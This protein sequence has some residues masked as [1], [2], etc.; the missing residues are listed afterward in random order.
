MY[1]SRCSGFLKGVVS[2]LCLI[3]SV[4]VFAESIRTPDLRL[5]IDISETAL[6]AEQDLRLGQSLAALVRL[7]PEG[8]QVG[9]WTF[10]E[11]VEQLAPVKAV[12]NSWKEAAALALVRVK[13]RGSGSDIPAALA[14]ASAILP[15][16]NANYDTS[17]ILLTSGRLA[18]S[19]SPM[20]NANAAREL[21]QKRAPA[22]A[23]QGIPVHT[24]AVSKDADRIFLANL[25]RLT[26]GLAVRA[27]SSGELASSLLRL[28]QTISPV[29]TL[30]IDKSRFYVDESVE[31]FT[32][33]LTGGATLSHI[34]LYSPDGDRVTREQSPP[35][36]R[37]FGNDLFTLITVSKPQVGQWKF[38]AADDAE[39]QVRVQ[40][41]LQLQIA[42]SLSVI[43]VGVTTELTLQLVLAG[44]TLDSVALYS[45]FEVSLAV[46]NPTGVI[47]ALPADLV[48]VKVSEAGYVLSLPALK[49]AGSHVFKIGLRGEGVQRELPVYVTA[50]AANPRE[51]ISTRVED[52]PEVDLK[53]P[54]I[55]FA[56]LTVIAL[57]VLLMVLRR[58]RQRKLA[59]WQQRFSDPEGKGR[60]GLFPG[61]RAEV[62]RDNKRS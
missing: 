34:A 29:S 61:I 59:L 53:I 9:I 15:A 49:Q 6:G 23:S 17:I 42:P 14:A 18:V 37:W 3:L 55:R 28:L 45:Q 30:P 8:S 43:P 57:A 44:K 31:V 4:P 50:V 47:E 41:P 7:L 52:V 38:K 58:R 40:S 46:V 12:D 39:A 19:S 13:S 22:L 24:I 27:R 1:R 33:L 54:A 48:A 20:T 2:A 60:S 26:G 5:I 32:L 51:I 16:P 25:A 10:D 11:T 35:G 21:I 62:K 36:M 56:V